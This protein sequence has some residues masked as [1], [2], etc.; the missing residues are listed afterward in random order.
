MLEMMLPALVVYYSAGGSTH[1]LNSVSMFT[2]YL[3]FSR[4][5]LGALILIAI[6]FFLTPFEVSLSTMAYLKITK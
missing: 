1:N 2:S 5:N 4:T 3:N 6:T